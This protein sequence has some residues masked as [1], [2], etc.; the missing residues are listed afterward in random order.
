MLDQSLCIPMAVLHSA[1]RTRAGK[2]ISQREAATYLIA[3][4]KRYILYIHIIIY[5]II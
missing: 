3:A 4:I 5:I 2:K 1:D